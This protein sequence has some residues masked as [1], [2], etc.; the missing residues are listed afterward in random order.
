MTTA[1]AASGEPE[2]APKAEPKH[3]PV[4]KIIS[5]VLAALIES[6]TE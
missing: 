6:K 4:Y 1:P 5:Q 2:E 3:G